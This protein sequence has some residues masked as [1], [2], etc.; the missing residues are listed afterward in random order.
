MSSSALIVSKSTSGSWGGLLDAG[1]AKEHLLQGVAAQSE[2]ERLESDD[3]LRRDV[4]EV[5]LGAEVLDEP[6]LRALRRRLPDQ[7]VE[8]DRV[9]DLI[10]EPGAE[11]SGRPVAPGCAALA[12]LGDDLP[13]ARG[14]LVAHPP[15]PELRGAVR[16]RVLRAARAR[17]ALPRWDVQEGVSVKGVHRC[18]PASCA[19]A[20]ARRDRGSCRGR[21]YRR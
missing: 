8:A 19:R 21:R 4:P 20:P 3:L 10:D 13:G 11:L 6:G 2:T 18:P 1:M 16:V 7:V 12:A 5:H 9:L 15:P 14:D 17:L